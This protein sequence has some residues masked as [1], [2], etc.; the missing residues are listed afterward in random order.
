MLR[1]GYELEPKTFLNF[2][3]KKWMFNIHVDNLPFFESLRMYIVRSPQS[4][5]DH[6]HIRDGVP[7]FGH[8]GTNLDI[9]AYTIIVYYTY[10]KVSSSDTSHCEFQEYLNT[11]KSV[12]WI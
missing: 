7:K 5:D 6:D 12:F 2:C 10:R 4:C 3:N 8:K 11:Q 1:L 9:V